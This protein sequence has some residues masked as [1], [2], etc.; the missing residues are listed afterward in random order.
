MRKSS[1]GITQQSNSYPSLHT[2]S[3]PKLLESTPLA[4]WIMTLSGKGA[5][6]DAPSS[7]GLSGRDNT[8]DKAIKG[9]VSN[10]GDGLAPAIIAVHI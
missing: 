6:T 1:K 4:S 9:G 10:S 8:L 2:H 3:K 7:I 5:K